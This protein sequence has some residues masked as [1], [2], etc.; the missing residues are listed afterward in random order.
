MQVL[1]AC[2]EEI[3]RRSARRGVGERMYA[4]RSWNGGAEDVGRVGRQFYDVFRTRMPRA[5]MLRRLCH[6]MA[7]PRAG[8]ASC[9]RA[10]TLCA[11]DR[12]LNAAEA[13]A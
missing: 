9:P 4:L 2:V 10:S 1:V 12:G 11:S 5:L 6:V 13:G 7:R 8:G 3:T